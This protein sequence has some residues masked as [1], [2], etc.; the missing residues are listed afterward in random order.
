MFRGILEEQVQV[1]R[2]LTLDYRTSTAYVIDGMAVVQIMKKAE[3][4]VT[5][6]EL[7]NKYFQVITA[8]LGNNGRHCVDVV[9]DCNEKEDL[10]KE[11]HHAQRR[12][13]SSFEVRTSQEV[14]KLHLQPCEQE[15][16]KGISWHCMERDGKD[17]AYCDKKLVLAG[18][19]IHSNDTL[20]ITQNQENPLLHSPSISCSNPL[21]VLRR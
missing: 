18:C 9:F 11:A 8:H 2:R 16:P 17:K 3:G 6:E 5:F 13:S 14:A 19:F 12:S 20:A 4:S 21:E 1:Q 10:I 15:Q 7:T